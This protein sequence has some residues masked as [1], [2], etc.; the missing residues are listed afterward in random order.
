[1]SCGNPEKYKIKDVKETLAI[2]Y[3]VD[4]PAKNC[5]DLISNYE[6]EC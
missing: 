6:N 1:M 4:I 2:S 5:C 3:G